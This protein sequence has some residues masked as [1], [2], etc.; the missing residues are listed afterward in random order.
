M[1]C[2]FGLIDP[3]H[4]LS[5]RQKAR[6]L[7]SLSIACEARGTD[8]TGI[9]YRSGGR[10]RIHKKP[11]PAH[12]FRFFL[13]DDAYTVMGHTR[14]TTQGS[15]SKTYNNHP[16]P[17]TVNGH[18]FALAHN[19]V[20]YNDKTLRRNLRLPN[21]K[22]ETDSYVAV[23]LIERQKA[24]S[25][26]SL[27]SMA[28]SVEGSFT[29]TI[30]DHM[31]GL[32]F[33]K[34]ENPLCLNYYP[35]LG[36]YVYASTKEILNGGLAH[37]LLKRETAEEVPVHTEE[38]LYLSTD[39]TIARDTFTLSWNWYGPWSGW[40]PGRRSA[41][42]TL[43]DPWLKELRDMAGVFG[44]RPEDIDEMATHGMSTDEIEEAL[45]VGEL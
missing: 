45:Y 39:G 12:Q 36:L 27:R 31:N 41:S 28:E 3:R 40:F 9:A 15:A 17:G 42:A 4:S 30:L 38:I 7:H 8:A 26:S 20:L 25:F 24:L 29:F 33:V 6:L 10:L 5:G 34:G 16:F 22:I 32:Y 23:Q 37:T 43:G 35:R 19:G 11:L 13:P 18:T 44:Y 21:T 1:C 2:L 14:M